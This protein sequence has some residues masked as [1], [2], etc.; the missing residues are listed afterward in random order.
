M[1]LWCGRG[2]VDIAGTVC[3][4]AV[5]DVVVAVLCVYVDVAVVCVDVVVCVGLLCLYC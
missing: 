4:F 5:A 3:V 2:A 1:L